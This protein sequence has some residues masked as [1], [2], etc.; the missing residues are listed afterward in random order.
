MIFS[1]DLQSLK[2][3]VDYL[4]LILSLTLIAT[5]YLQL[6]ALVEWYAIEANSLVSLCTLHQGQDNLEDLRY[7]NRDYIL[8]S[9]L[10]SIPNPNS[11]STVFFKGSK[12]FQKFSKVN[13]QINKLFSELSSRYPKDHVKSL[14]TICNVV[15]LKRKMIYQ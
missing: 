6:L 1:E 14:E 3:F 12:R 5:R 9:K 13:K 11:N 15:F 4:Q 2:T 7:A 8:T 10:T